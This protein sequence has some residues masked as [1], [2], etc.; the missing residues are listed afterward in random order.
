VNELDLAW[1][2]LASEGRTEPGWHGR[3]VMLAA[4]CRIQA[5]IRP[6]VGSLGVL[7]DVASS[8]VPAAVDYPA[9]AGFVL[10]PEAISPGPGGRVRLVLEERGTAYRDVF[11]A[12]AADVVQRVAAAPDEAT[13]VQVLLSRLQ[14][15]LRFAARFGPGLLST[16]AQTGLVGELLFLENYILGHLPAGAAVAAWT[17]PGGAAQDFRLSRC[18]VE[19]KASTALSPSSMRISNLAQLDGAAGMPLFLCHMSLGLA[20][21]AARRLP[22][23]IIDLRTRLSAEPDGALEAFGDSLVEAGFLEIHSPHYLAVAYVLRGAIF[24]TVA[25]DFPRLTPSLVPAA[26]EAATY[27][28]SLAACQPWI[29]DETVCTDLIGESSSTHG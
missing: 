16:D 29:V 2:E 12:M 15:W 4:P 21:P 19:I 20:G 28:L 17:G 26:V 27:S 13:S 5:A 23:I 9:C 25:E 11:L 1:S 14:V 22:D 10:A 3:R 8:V 7:F 18:Y 6:G 24:H